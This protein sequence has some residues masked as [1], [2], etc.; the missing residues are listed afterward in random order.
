LAK[1]CA[2]WIGDHGF[3]IGIDDVTPGPNLRK[4][5]DLLKE[6][7]YKECSEKIDQFKLGGYIFYL[8]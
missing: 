6:T 7:G 1:L 5:K 2:R 8:I 3:S 4:R